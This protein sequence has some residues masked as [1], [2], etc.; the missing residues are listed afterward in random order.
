MVCINYA[1]HNMAMVC[2]Q[3]EAESEVHAAWLV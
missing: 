1:L 3:H 2:E